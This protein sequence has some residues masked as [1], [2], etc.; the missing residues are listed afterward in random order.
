MTAK[1]LIS[2]SIPPL[3]TSDTGEK[4]I[5]WMNELHIAHLPIVNNKKLLGVITEDDILD[6]THPE[7]TIEKQ[8]LSLARPFVYAHQHLYDVIKIVS[9]LQLTAIPVVDENE[10]YV[11]LIT[12]ER[13]IQ[14]FAQLSSVQEPGGLIM[15]VMSTKDYS[16]AE[17]AQIVESNDASVLSAYVSSHTD[18]T[19]L[20]VTIKVNRL[21]LRQII[22]TF[23]RYEYNVAASVQESDHYDYLKDRLDSLMN[24]LNT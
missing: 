1:H 10:E 13:I 14:Q 3:K 7:L 12:L 15:L 9:D 17:I 2:E 8:A 11:G 20:E 21:D 22:A 23:E 19:K 6:L 18:S 4:A 5:T 24:Y 16:L